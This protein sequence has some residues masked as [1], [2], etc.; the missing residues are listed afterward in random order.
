MLSPATAGWNSVLI[1][2]DLIAT[3]RRLFV[4]RRWLSLTSHQQPTSLRYIM[5]NGRCF[6]KSS[7]RFIHRQY[8]KTL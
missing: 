8:R 7:A 1:V 4:Q 2:G 6:Q 5:K 3:S